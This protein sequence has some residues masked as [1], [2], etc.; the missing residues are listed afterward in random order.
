MNITK[1]TEK[2]SATAEIDAVALRLSTAFP[3]NGQAKK[4]QPQRRWL[5][6]IFTAFALLLAAGGAQA[7]AVVSEVT[8]IAGTYKLDAVVDITVV[9]S[10]VV[11]LP[12]N[13]LLF[14][15]M[16]G[17]GEARYNTGAGSTKLVFK[18]SVRNIDDTNM[19]SH[20]ENTMITLGLGTIIETSFGG[21]VDL[22]LPDPPVTFENVVLD[23]IVPTVPEF[24]DVAA[25][26]DV[27]ADNYINAAE[28]AAA[29]TGT[30]EAGTTI[31]LCFG[32]TDAACTGGMSRLTTADGTSVTVTGTTWR[33]TLT[34]ADITAMGQDS[35]T[36]RITATDAAGN[37]THGTRDITV[38]TIFPGTTATIDSVIETDGGA[39]VTSGGTTAATSLTLSGM[40]DTT[41]LMVN[42]Y[43]G[44]DMLGSVT[45]VADGGWSYTD[46]TL[47][48]GE[49]RNYTAAVA[50]TAGN[51]G[52]SSNLFTITAV[53]TPTVTLVQAPHGFYMEG[54]SIPITIVFSEAVSVTDIPQ[55]A[56]STGNS[57]GPGI[58]N[59]SASGVDF[60]LTFT[61]TVRAGDNIGEPQGIPIDETSE[62]PASLND[63][64]YTGTDALTGTI[65][66]TNTGVAADLTLPTPGERA[67]LSSSSDVVLDTTVP[68]V[69]SAAVSADGTSIDVTVSEMLTLTNLDSLDGDE[70]ILTG[71]TTAA[72]QFAFTLG[73]MLLLGVDPAI[74]P[75]ESVMLTWT[76]GTDDIIADLAGN[77]LADIPTA[78]SVAT[79]AVVLAA[80]V[81][82]DV[83]VGPFSAPYN[84]AGDS[85]NIIVTFSSSVTVTDAPQL[86]LDIGS[87]NVMAEYVPG[88]APGTALTFR[89]NVLD[90]HNS[91]ALAYPDVNALG[92]NGGSIQSTIVPATAANPT[93]PAPG[94][95]NSLS[96]N[97]FVSTVVID[98]IV[99][100]VP[101]ID[102]PATDDDNLITAAERDSNDPVS[103]YGTHAD[104]ADT[105][106]TLCA[107]AMDVTDPLCTGGLTYIAS[108]IS[109]L[110]FWSY[111][112]ADDDITEIGDGVVTLTAIATDKASNAAVSPGHDITVD[113][114]APTADSAVASADGMSIAVTVSEAVTLTNLDGTEFTLDGGTSA[115]VTAVSA[116]GTTLTLTVSPAILSGEEVTLAWTAGTNDIIADAAGTPMSNFDSLTVLTDMVL[117]VTAPT[118]D[119]AVAN[120]AGTRIDV[121]VSERVALTNLET[122]DGTEFTLRGTLA[123]VTAVT[124]IVGTTLRLTVSPPIRAVEKVTLAWTAGTND[125]IADAAGNPMSDFDSLRVM[126][127]MV[128]GPRLTFD[129]VATDNTINIAEQD[130]GVTIRGTRVA[131]TT[132]TLCIAGS[133]AACTGGTQ[134]A[135]IIE[136]TATTW[137]YA[138][139]AADYTAAGQG[140]TTFTAT[141]RDADG[142]VS[143]VASHTIIVDTMAPLP[144]TFDVVSASSTSL[145]NNGDRLNAADSIAGVL[146][147]GGLEEDA[148]VTLCLAGTGD[149]TGASCGTDRTLRAGADEDQRLRWSYMLTPNDIAEMSEGPETV[150]ATATDVAGNTS[151]EGSYDLTVDTGIPE[152]R[153]GTTGEVEVGSAIG[154]TAYNAE[155]TDNGLASEDADTDI[156]YSLS[157]SRVGTTFTVMQTGQVLVDGSFVNRTIE[158]LVITVGASVFDI[159]EDNGEVTYKEVQTSAITHG[160]DIVATD[161]AGNRVVQTVAISV[162]D[163]I[164]PTLG[165]AGSLT[166]APAN[167]GTVPGT[168]TIEL[169]GDTFTT[170]V[171][172]DGSVTASGIPGGMTA[173]FGRTDS[174]TV[175]LM[176]TGTATVHTADVDLTIAFG[177]GAFSTENAATIAD[178]TSIITI[179]FRG[180]SSLGYTGSLTEAPANDG[181]VPGTITIE[182]TGDTFT[183]NVHTDGSVTAT[184]IP[185]GMTAVFGRTDSTT[186]TLMLTGTATAH[187]ADMDLTIAFGDGAFSMENAATI[188]DSTSIITIDFRGASSLAYTGSLTEAPANDGTIPGTITIELTGD[189]FT[190]NVHTDGSVTA[191]GIPGGMTAV[192]GRT[193]STTVTL[194][195]TGTATAHV[196]DMD[197]TITFGDGAFSTEDAATIDDSTSIITIDFRGASSLA[198][199]G[200]LTEAP[201]NDGT[202]PGTITIEL[203]GDTFTTNVHTDGSVTASGIPGG[204]TAVFG[205]TDST[206][207]CHLTIASE[208]LGGPAPTSIGH[209][210]S[211][212]AA[213]DSPGR[214]TGP[215]HRRFGPAVF[216]AA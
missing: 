117:D 136:D 22:T 150:T 80:P 51:E 126:T 4:P 11:E 68:T 106:I 67:S 108:T 1:P 52:Q 124:S 201:T 207:T 94:E 151:A 206:A 113:L 18:Y 35:E 138:L 177:N 199:T 208:M 38:D 2:L 171:H 83:A 103:I 10:E 90:G 88:G 192:F 183:T 111:E 167:D 211:L 160:I 45:A 8:A 191:T 12:D 141:A 193:D 129:A 202:I 23:G 65:Q 6:A 33:Y 148:T 20:A 59:Y 5:A 105:I 174:T 170:N 152:F 21:E 155:A 46:T 194:M 37:P 84:K 9:F 47:T 140:A 166:E 28:Q 115:Q 92:L 107:G 58:A 74:Q 81:V 186:V 76:A 181:T 85:V 75:G 205:R 16:K 57:A 54:E 95:F 188:A 144:P 55:L 154:V 25:N 32:G 119:S 77:R 36:L 3:A 26:N 204:M 121:T 216:P 98:T 163:T 127:D 164:A 78:L 173:V 87:P 73:N 187:V 48:P 120:S 196:A 125:I 158:V 185:G 86:T 14:L 53:A 24:D 40:G 172:T 114:I 41:D 109:G 72:V 133:G 195:L 139:V 116:A 176:L 60:T 100:A 96:G 179:D 43:D 212:P 70:F 7:Q 162:V 180:A 213:D 66:S 156:N 50:D 137:S 135:T 165:Y 197:L 118:A 143:L 71:T 110:T 91:A 42:I 29:L 102:D 182:L 184:G 153:S 203:T 34:A 190:T 97:F 149:V 198:Y 39:T 142:M 104:E 178:S 123:Q 93:L 63:L 128:D 15:S 112:L 101:T 89:Y 99:P 131:E 146:W 209:R 168:I 214:M 13:E 189:T 147:G 69:L 62:V 17:G 132:V 56:L 134:P 175:T 30:T 31:T 157:A 200:S 27:V 49:A 64:A 82:V 210:A 215:D 159:D 19:F 145:T 169:T 122:L 44:T 79:D 161:L 61:Y 130:N